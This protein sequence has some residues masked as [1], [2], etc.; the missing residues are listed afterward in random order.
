MNV[1]FLS[2]KSDNSFT[3]A[4]ISCSDAR[5]W[6]LDDELTESCDLLLV[7]LPHDSIGHL[8]ELIPLLRKGD[9]TLLR[10]WA[11]TEREDLDSQKQLIIDAVE[12]SSA[13]IESVTIEEIKGFSSSKC[14]ACFE[15]WLTRPI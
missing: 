13:T 9:I 11:I 2:S 15:V 8:P 7:N 3:P 12:N 10:G 4:T 14:F 6:A 5:E 1:E